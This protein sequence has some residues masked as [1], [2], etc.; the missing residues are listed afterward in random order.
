MSIANNRK[1]AVIEAGRFAPRRF[2]GQDDTY[3]T[4]LSTNIT[5][6]SRPATRAISGTV[7]RHEAAAIAAKIAR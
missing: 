4:H 3:S 6:L 2:N 1:T 5:K 7:A